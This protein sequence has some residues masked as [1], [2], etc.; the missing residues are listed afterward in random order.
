MKRGPEG[1]EHLVGTEGLP[2]GSQ[3]FPGE[4]SMGE[5]QTHPTSRQWRQGTMEGPYASLSER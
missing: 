3:S 1:S 4:V 2:P 5:I